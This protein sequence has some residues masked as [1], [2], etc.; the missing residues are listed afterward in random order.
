MD[1]FLFILAKTVS[2]FLGLVS[3]S[4]MARV[5]IPFF[6]D[7]EDN[8]VYVLACVISE[9]FITPVRAVLAAFNIGQDSPIDWAFFLAYLI[10]SFLRSAFPAI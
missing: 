10:L 5:I 2:V 7:A 1:I 6:F 8:S 4:M 3:L 9:P